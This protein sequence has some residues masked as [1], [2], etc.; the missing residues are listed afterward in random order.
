MAGPDDGILDLQRMIFDKRSKVFRAYY[1]PH[2]HRPNGFY[3]Y[4]IRETYAIVSLAIDEGGDQA[5]T[6][7]SYDEG[8]DEEEKKK[9][10]EGGDEEEATDEGGDEEEEAIGELFCV[11]NIKGTHAERIVIKKLEGALNLRSP[12]TTKHVRVKIYMNYSPCN[13]EGCCDALIQFKADQERKKVK[14]NLEVIVAN[15]YNINRPR[16][17]EDNCQHFTSR[18]VSH[19]THDQNQEGLRDLNRENILLRTFTTADWKFVAKVLSRGDPEEERTLMDSKQTNEPTRDVED[20]RVRDD[21]DRI[22][23]E[24]Q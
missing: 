11:T 8:G 20:G 12:S 24:G 17:V 18:P 4:T 1:A 16:C 5:T 22:L 14:V 2:V 6:K 15:L 9:T 7:K 3:N 23:Q 19:T 10:D 21:L 13:Q